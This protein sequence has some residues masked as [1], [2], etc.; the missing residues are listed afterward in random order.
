MATG[1]SHLLI[2][3]RILLFRNNNSFTEKFYPITKSLGKLGL[4]AVVDGKILVLTEDG[5]VKQMLNWCFI[6]L[7]SSVMRVKTW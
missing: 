4:D 3:V 2:K 7:T 1:R 5:E 6:F